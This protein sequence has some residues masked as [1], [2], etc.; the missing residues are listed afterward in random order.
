MQLID[1]MDL[2]ALRSTVCE[3][4]VPIVPILSEFVRK[5]WKCPASSRPSSV[6]LQVMSTDHKDY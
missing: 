5:N 4:S 1:R 3:P 2:I 6:L